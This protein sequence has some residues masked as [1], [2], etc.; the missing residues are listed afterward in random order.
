MIIV[1]NFL[2]IILFKG[3]NVPDVSDPSLV[4]I[5]PVEEFYQTWSFITLSCVEGYSSGRDDLYSYCYDNGEWV[6]DPISFVCYGTIFV[7]E[8]YLILK[9]MKK[10]PFFN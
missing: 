9:I 6:P 4:V 2:C 8:T 1:W 10:E 3:C 7:T 5:D